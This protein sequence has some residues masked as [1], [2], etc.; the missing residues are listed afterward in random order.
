MESKTGIVSKIRVLKLTASPLVRFNLDDT[1][2][3]I[4]TH[5]LSFLADVDEGSRVALW[6]YINSR[7]QFVVRKY[8]V[9]GGTSIMYEFN[10]SRYPTRVARS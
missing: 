3:L 8:T 10:H 4:A 9:L 5:S 6:G 2:C 1:S 7:N